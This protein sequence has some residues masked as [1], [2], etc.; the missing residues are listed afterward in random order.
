M[1]PP[2]RRTIRQS[3]QQPGASP[4]PVEIED[5]RALVVPVRASASS[6]PEM[7]PEGDPVPYPSMGEVS[8]AMW[9]EYDDDSDHGSGDDID[10][11]G[12]G[13]ATT[14][15]RASE[16]FG[17]R[18]PQRLLRFSVLS[19]DGHVCD[20]EDEDS[21]TDDGESEA[22]GEDESDGDE[23]VTSRR[24]WLGGRRGRSSGPSH[25]SRERRRGAG[26]R[27][28]RASGAR[29]SSKKT[30]EE[31]EF[32]EVD[33]QRKE[34][35]ASVLRRLRV[36]IRRMDGALTEEKVWFVS[37]GRVCSTSAT[38]GFAHLKWRRA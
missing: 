38:S 12:R 36:A 28:E 2:P 23:R 19:L 31:E 32:D 8:S 37:P 26:N 33:C 17:R 1:S 9:C 30:E 14:G 5:L 34:E 7:S 27:G 18:R 3:R 22:D 16:M 15:R 21:E 11:G 20:D 24:S 4:E 25:G 6:A 13:A 35:L 10:D 29:K